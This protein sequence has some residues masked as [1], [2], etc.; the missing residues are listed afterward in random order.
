VVVEAG[1][2]ELTVSGMT[3]RDVG[4]VAADHHIALTELTPQSATLEEAFMEI[5]R[6]DV[7]FHADSKA[8]NAS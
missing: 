3:S 7:E 1:D 4:R 6:D 8:V 5:T 2:N